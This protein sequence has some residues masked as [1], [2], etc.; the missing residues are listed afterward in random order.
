V[1]ALRNPGSVIQIGGYRVRILDPANA[2]VMF[3]D[4][5]QHEIYRFRPA[6]SAPRVIDCGSNIGMSIL[7]FKQTFPD[8]H[9]T[10]FEADPAVF[11]TLTHNVTQNGL[12][13]VQLIEAAV[14]SHEGHATFARRQD[15]DGS[16]FYD[17]RDGVDATYEVRTVSLRPWL[18]EHVDF[19]KLNIE[20]AEHDVLLDVAD[21]LPNVREL[22]VEYHHEPGLARTLDRI[23]RLLS[24]AGFQYLIHDFDART[25]AGSHPPF[26][27]NADSRYYLLIYATRV[28]K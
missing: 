24:E 7:Y 26:N 18:E 23:L 28:E 10:A 25:N 27:L 20:G 16:L 6:T 8:A 22:V 17:Q 4:I 11:E 3:K 15:Y 21:L 14:S 19:L 5:F 12:V 9:I 13:G 2:Y 1:T